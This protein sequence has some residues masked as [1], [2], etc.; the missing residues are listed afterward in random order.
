M[1]PTIRQY[2]DAYRNAMKG[3]L[4]AMVQSGHKIFREEIKAIVDS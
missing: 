2:R 3:A 1:D 4:H